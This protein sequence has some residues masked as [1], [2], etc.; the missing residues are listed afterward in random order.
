LYDSG[1]NGFSDRTISEDRFFAVLGLT[2]ARTMVRGMFAPTRVTMFIRPAHEK[3]IMSAYETHTNAIFRTIGK[4][5]MQDREVRVN[6]AQLMGFC[7][8]GIAFSSRVL[9]IPEPPR[10]WTSFGF[11]VDDAIPDWLRAGLLV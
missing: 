2:L 11:D 6:V 1:K 3:W 7:L 8:M 5:P 4:L 10:L 9:Q